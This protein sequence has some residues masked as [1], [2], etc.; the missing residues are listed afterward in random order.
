MRILF[1]TIGVLGLLL[2]T[3]CTPPIQERIATMEQALAS[4]YSDGK[5]DS[6]VQLYRTAVD[7]HTEKDNI[8]LDYLTKGANLLFYK[9]NDAK[10]A[11][12]W[13]NEAIDK[14]GKG[15]HL[16]PNIAL[17][18]RIWNAYTY[19]AAP[20]INMDPDDI[21]RLHANLLKN[22]NWIDSALVQLDHD[23]TNPASGS[24][25]PEKAQAFIEIS[26]AESTLFNE[27]NQTNRYVDALLR[28]AGLAKTVGN[29]NKALQLYYKVEHFLPNHPKAPT[30]LFMTG[31]I[32][33][34]DLHDLTKAKFT[35]E[36]FLKRYPNDPDYTDDAKQA[37]GMLGKSAEELVREFEKM[38]STTKK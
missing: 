14:Y 18:S 34:N 33:E 4:H 10:S 21:D 32:Y 38:S 12:R 13:L 3:A 28:A 9:R 5:A 35:Y 7:A 6:L 25:A 16:T 20:A 23:M 29:P 17:S 31:F 30:A 27:L 24:I 8:N 22:M 36:S 11:V 2:Q 19:K 26:E 37:L 15:Q 1:A